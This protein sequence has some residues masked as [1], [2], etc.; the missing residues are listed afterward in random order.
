MRTGQEEACLREDAADHQGSAETVR[1]LVIVFS[2]LVNA[3]TREED[4]SCPSLGKELS[5]WPGTP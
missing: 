4:E 3:P 2:S 5:D 1:G